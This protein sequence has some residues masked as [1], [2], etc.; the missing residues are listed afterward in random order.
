MMDQK[1]EKRKTKIAVIDTNVDLNH[2]I[3]KDYYINVEGNYLYNRPSGHGTA[4][5]GIIA[6]NSVHSE[7]VVFQ[8]FQDDSSD[9]S[10]ELLIKT[11]EY[12]LEDGSY[13][14]VNISNGVI[15][16]SEVKRLYKVCAELYKNNTYIVS[17]YDN[18]SI[19]TY[20][21]CFDCVIGVDNSEEMHNK[22]DY[23]WNDN[24]PVNISGYAGVQRVA[25]TDNKYVIASGSSFLCPLITAIVSEALYNGKQVKEILSEKA[26]K[27]IYQNSQEMEQVPFEIYKGIIF[28]YNKEMHAIARFNSMLKWEVYGVYDIK[29][30][31]NL[32]K[33]PNE[34]FEKRDSFRVKNYEEIVWNSDFDTIIIGHI[35]KIREILGND[36]VREL[37]NNAIKNNK[38]IYTYDRFVADCF[39]NLL[40]FS[41]N[42]TSKCYYPTPKI[43]NIKGSFWGK[44]WIPSLP[45]IAVM[46]TNSKQGKYTLQLQM[47]QYF[48]NIGYKIAHL[49]TEPNGWLL[50]SSAVF[51]FGD[52]NLRNISEK[53]YILY[54]NQIIHNID[55]EDKYDLI[56]TGSQS[57]TIPQ[58]VFIGE[59]LTV[60]QNAFLH[61]MA[62]DGV[63]LSTSPEDDIEYI[64]RT[65][66]HIESYVNTKVIGIV[67]FPMEKFVAS[68]GQINIKSINGTDRMQR[69]IY[70]LQNRFSGLVLE[71]GETTASILSEEIIK[72]LS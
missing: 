40:R 47:K 34:F 61:G 48:E 26:K 14:I 67:I 21:A 63:I 6:K 15:V 45:I 5:C 31:S 56:L 25:W 70:E 58:N 3:F 44:M 22:N 23:I 51:H 69:R 16:T 72:F 29:Y 19:M 65:V 62:P 27:C 38:N 1:I 68:N 24:S 57:N 17:A 20:P 12:I 2:D 32:G 18:S 50:G 64:V 66:N 55:N 49:S 37:V 53:D 33:I 11:L 28:P 41:S 43:G 71:L 52:N 60:A 35:K 42:S 39:E 9:V 59:D 10:M 4:V 7:I 8:I 36:M 46:G 54:I 13:Q 30:S